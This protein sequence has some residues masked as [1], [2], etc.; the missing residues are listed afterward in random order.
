M[1]VAY[2]GYAPQFHASAE[3]VAPNAPQVCVGADAHLRPF[4]GPV[5]LPLQLRHLPGIHRSEHAQ[6]LAQVVGSAEHHARDTQ[7][8]G[9]TH[10]GLVVVDEDA[11]PGLESIALEQYAEQPG[12]WLDQPLGTA[13]YVVVNHLQYAETLACR[14][15]CLH[16]PV[17]EAVDA[18]VGLLFQF[19]Q[20]LA[21]ALHLAGQHLL[22]MRVVHFYSFLVFRVLRRFFGDAGIVALRRH[23][24]A[25]ASRGRTRGA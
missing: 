14:G 21:H 5:A 20:H 4:V 24:Y 25:G 11:L 19:G 16:A 12:I 15:E 9:S 8:F 22:P 2:R 6:P 10:V 1:A 23:R 13:D 7:R 18:H 17:G 3:V